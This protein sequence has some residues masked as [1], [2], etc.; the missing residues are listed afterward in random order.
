M[1]GAVAE[2]APTV[3]VPEVLH[4][5]DGASREL[6]TDALPLRAH[7]QLISRREL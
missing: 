5:I 6:L 4:W 2:H 3:M 7:S 1:L